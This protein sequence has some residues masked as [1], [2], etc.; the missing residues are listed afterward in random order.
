[1]TTEDCVTTLSANGSGKHSDLGLCQL[2]PPCLEENL[3]VLDEEL[4][5]WRRNLNILDE[6]PSH[7]ST[8]GELFR[9]RVCNSWHL[10]NS[11]E[12][13]K[14]IKSKSRVVFPSWCRKKMLWEGINSGSRPQSHLI[15]L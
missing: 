14:A 9:R 3:N 12:M 4:G 13:A 6:E 7:P 5:V 15:D 11:T 8:V 2:Q 10:L 1:M